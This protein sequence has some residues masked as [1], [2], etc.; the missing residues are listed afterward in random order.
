MNAACA[1]CAAAL[2]AGCGEPPAALDMGEVD[3]SAPPDAGSPDAQLPL[4]LSAMGLY[5]D[6][7]S[8]TIAPEAVEYRPAHELWS[9]GAD[10]QRWILL[11]GAIDSS[12]MDHWQFPVGTKLFKNFVAGGVLV[13]TRLIWRTG[14]AASDYFMGAF[15]WDED[16]RDAVFVEEGR[17]DALGT[18]HDVPR[19]VLC[20]DCHEG[21]PGRILGFSAVQ[22]S[23]DGPG[24]SLASI[25][26]DGWLSNP[27]A[28]GD[29]FPPPGDD[30]TAAAL[31]TLHANCGNCHN[32]IGPAYEDVSMSLRLS[33]GEREPEA[34]QLWLTTV[35]VALEK[36]TVP[37]YEVRIAPGDPQASAV[38]ARMAIRG[39]GIDQMPPIATEQPDPAGLAAVSSWIATLAK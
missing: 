5:A 12:D 26:A 37:P 13:E 11:G 30:V 1:L 10:K 19:A 35:G 4:R 18:Q 32:P 27:P 9:D 17:T 20:W 3:A 21:E 7:E 14:E 24:A 33:V 31:G 39:G 2:V 38:I 6:I 8:R 34:T 15:A 25:A 16:G 22:L 29:A 36:W 23:H 28:D